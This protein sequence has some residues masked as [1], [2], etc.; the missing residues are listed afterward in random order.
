[1]I[2]THYHYPVIL[3]TL[4]SD[5]TVT[6]HKNYASQSLP[7]PRA[8]YQLAG[9]TGVHVPVC[10]YAVRLMIQLESS[11]KCVIEVAV[12]EA[13]TFL[14]TYCIAESTIGKPYAHTTSSAM[15]QLYG[16]SK[17]VRRSLGV[18]PQ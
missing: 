15:G 10:Q 18:A 9:S 7:T 16:M 14:D 4:D 13:F 1:M 2:V 17:Y 12:E 3:A 6:T 5:Q 8:N 11:Q